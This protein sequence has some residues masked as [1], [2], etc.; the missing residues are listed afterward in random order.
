MVAVAAR[1]GGE[2]LAKRRGGETLAKSG[3]LAMWAVLCRLG[4]LIDAQCGH[5][6]VVAVAVA[7]WRW[8]W[9]VEAEL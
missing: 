4:S 3:N 5:W 8:R 1:Q 2:A 6:S 7:V 9:R